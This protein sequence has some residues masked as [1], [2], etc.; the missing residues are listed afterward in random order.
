MRLGTRHRIAFYVRF[1]LA[2]VVVGVG[3]GSLVAW[4]GA[5]IGDPLLG[6]AVGAI[7]GAVLSATIGGIDLFGMRTRLGRA[8]AR[9]PFAVT[10]AVKWVLY[11]TVVFA[12][13]GGRLASRT[14][15]PAVPPVREDPFVPL[16]IAF[17]LAASFAFLFVLEMS[18]LLG[19]RTLRDIVLGRYHR[20]RSEERCFLFV[21]IAGSTP[22][23]ERIGPIGVHR[24]LARV[25][26]LASGPVEDH[27]GE[28]YQYVGDE[29]VVTWT[30]RDARPAARPIACFFAI[31]AAVGGAA[32]DFERDFGVAPRLRAALHAG[33]VIAGEVGESR[34]AIVFHGD[35]MNTAS[36]LEEAARTLAR[37]FVASADALARLDGLEAYALEDLGLQP[38][39]GRAKPVHVHAI[40]PLS[41]R[42]AGEV[43]DLQRRSGQ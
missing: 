16:S 28:I 14:L 34:R 9:S 37:R 18:R 38:L 5:G 32:G 20:P 26:R 8:L 29:M 35:V 3:Y 39:R 27:G 10:F 15:G 2:A 25:F 21:D 17:S 43:V 30:L 36:R 31:E 41:P 33:P 19:G 42:R 6:A 1:V 12:V 24:F 22:L 13:V 40:E 11:G 4:A 23:A 7:N